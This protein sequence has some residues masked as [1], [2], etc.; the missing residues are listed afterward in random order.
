MGKSLS[1]NKKSQKTCI[2]VAQMGAGVVK[3]EHE[4]GRTS[5]H[6]NP[7]AAAESIFNP[8]KCQDCGALIPIFVKQAH[9]KDCGRMFCSNCATRSGLDSQ[10][11]KC[12]ILVNGKFTRAQLMMWKVK[13]LKAL[14]HK[15][16]INTATCS[17]KTELID[18][19]FSYYGNTPNGYADET[20]TIPGRPEPSE[21]TGT[22]RDSEPAPPPSADMPN[23]VRTGQT[24]E[25][26]NTSQLSDTQETKETTADNPHIRLEH[27]KSEDQIDELSNRC[28]KRLL[29]NNFVDF[30]GCRERQELVVRVKQLWKSN[31]INKQRAEAQGGGGSGGDESDICKICMDAAIDCVLLECGHMVSCTKCGKQL[32]ECP[33]CRQFVVRAVHIFKA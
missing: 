24:A 19:I 11:K 2:R 32:S 9:C 7:A 3:L 14:L 27:V 20:T 6:I 4:G 29:V 8:P 12:Y 31:E 13:D 10:C 30:K 25:E 23:T 28:L 17:E 26:S 22:P 5:V 16:N 21:N 33:V 18:L 1:K 15:Q